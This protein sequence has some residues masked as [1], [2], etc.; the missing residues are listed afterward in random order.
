M[1]DLGID[2]LLEAQIAPLKVKLVEMI[3]ASAGIASGAIQSYEIETGQTRQK[4]TKVN[5]DLL[6]AAIERLMNLLTT[7]EARLRGSG[8]VRM[9]PSW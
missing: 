7:L 8:A 2:E 4:V 1:S 9:I 5:L 6:E 3:A